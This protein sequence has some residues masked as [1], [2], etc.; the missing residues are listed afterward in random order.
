MYTPDINDIG[1]VNGKMK[2]RRVRLMIHD[3]DDDEMQVMQPGDDNRYEATNL[4]DMVFTLIFATLWAWMEVEMEGKHGW[5]V[6]LPT[7]CAF[8][9]WTWY[10][11]SMNV[12]VLTVMYYSLRFANFGRK[13]YQCMYYVLYVAAWFVVEDFAWFMINP[14]YG[15]RK[16]RQRDIFWHA[17]KTW[18][19]GTF[20]ENW[21]VLLA[22]IIMIGVELKYHHTDHFLVNLTMVTSYLAAGMTWSYVTPEYYSQPV[23]YNTGCFT[24]T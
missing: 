12:I 11:V 6:N 3:D 22:W 7:A 9:G 15:I 16:Y 4:S 2:P 8:Y 13:H 5:A 20:V 1:F 10:H 21:L 18:V 14:H 17:S 19:L 24:K 23:V